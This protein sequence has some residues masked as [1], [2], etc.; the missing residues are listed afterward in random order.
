VDKF[1][2]YPSRNYSPGELLLSAGETPKALF[3]LKAGYVRQF[4]DSKEGKELTIH[5]YEKG[6]IFPLSWGLNDETP[7]FTLSSI[8]K[9]EVT[10]VPRADFLKTIKNNPDE[11]LALTKRMIYAVSGLSKRIEI[12][13]FDNAKTRTITSLQYLYK[14]FGKKFEFTHED[15]SSLTG[16]TRERVSIEMKKLKNNGVIS[17]KRGAVAIKNI[18]KLV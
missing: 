18:S 14:H 11:L 7:N 5:I 6:A 10:L 3:F 13:N 16:L 15:L 4:V 2:K 1:T 9:S 17:Y 8:T 12:L